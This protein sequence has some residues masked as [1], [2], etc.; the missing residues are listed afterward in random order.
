MDTVLE[1]ATHSPQVYRAFINVMHLIAPPSSLFAP[2]IARQVI[3]QL[4]ARR[5]RSNSAAAPIAK[6]GMP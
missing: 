5:W 3:P 4:L 2:A 6:V 1:L